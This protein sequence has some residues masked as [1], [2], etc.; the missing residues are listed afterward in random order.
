[1]YFFNYF[2]PKLLV[3]YGNLT[4]GVDRFSASWVVIQVNFHVTANASG[5]ALSKRKAGQLPQVINV[6]QKPLHAW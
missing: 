1:M 3:T 2:L 5:P 6:H 4:N